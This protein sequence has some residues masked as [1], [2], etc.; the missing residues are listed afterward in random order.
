VATISAIG[1]AVIASATGPTALSATAP[2]G[3][4]VDGFYPIPAPELT[5]DKSTYS[6]NGRGIVRLDGFNGCPSVTIVIEGVPG[7]V[8][9]V[10][11]ENGT[12]TVDVTMPGAPGEYTITATCTVGEQSA[13]G[14]IE[15]R[16]I[17]TIT[18]PTDPPVT[19]PPTPVTTGGGR[20]P[21]T[22]SDAG[23][24]VLVGLVL[25][26]SGGGFLLVTRARRH[27]ALS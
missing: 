8:T 1:L 9:V 20:L 27:R 21:S 5:T 25:L 14:T 11:D 6:P 23:E 3:G 16:D 18:V 12:V 7:S 4:A 2:A 26:V 22:G 10:P 24:P 13:T 15:V 17:D 19:D